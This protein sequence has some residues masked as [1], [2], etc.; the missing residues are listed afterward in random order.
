MEVALYEAHPFGVDGG[1]GY[2]DDGAGNG[3]SGDG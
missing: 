1:S 2:G 3:G